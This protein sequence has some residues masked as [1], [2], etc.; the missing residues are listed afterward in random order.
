MPTSS[1]NEHKDLSFWHATAPE[2]H[3]PA[4]DE[5]TEADVAIVGA[6]FTGLWTAYYLKSLDPALSVAVVEARFPGFGASGRNGGW[7]VGEMAGMA[8]RFADPA[9]RESAIRLQRAMF[10]TVD[11]IGRVTR[12]E[13]IDCH[14][15]KGGQ[16]SLATAPVY[17]EDLRAD[18]EYWS[19]LGFGKEDF[20]W[21]EADEVAKHVRSPRTLGALYSPHCAVVHPLRLVSGLVDVLQRDGV[22]IYCDTPATRIEKG[23]VLTPGGSIRAPMIVRATEAY[24][25]TIPGNRRQLLPFHSMMI[26]TEPLPAETWDEIGLAARETF[27]DPRRMVI[28]GQ[29]TADDRIAFGARGGYLFGSKI[30]SE[31]SPDEDCF[32]QARD[33]LVELFP[34]LEG[35][36]VTHC[37]G[38]ALGISRDWRPAVGIDRQEGRGWAGGYVGE[39]V[40]ASNLAGRTLADLILE[41]DSALVDMP[42][43]GP[44]FGKWEPEPLRW[45][46]SKV[47]NRLG[48]YLDG[49]E[50][51]GRRPSGLLNSVYDWIVQK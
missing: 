4:L 16:V 51:A 40:A 29:R 33:T 7:A 45:I 24:T 1:E 10:Q 31:F 27:G 11:E 44:A 13:G 32:Q 48:D 46:G 34:V 43:V 6:G 30:R 22:R 19:A 23:R 37:W 17:A 15:A 35:V 18:A 38:G 9:T 36:G 49:A 12:H 5:E 25:D 20:C 39:G 14:Y 47:M 41:R 26:A 42:W 21:L 28:Y 50:L 2:V 8:T 3:S